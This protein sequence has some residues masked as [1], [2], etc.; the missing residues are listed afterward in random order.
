[1]ALLLA[2]ENYIK[3]W[4]IE[5]ALQAQLMYNI[6]LV[7]CLVK[8]GYISED[9]L[10]R[11]SSEIYKI[12]ILEPD[13]WKNIPFEIIELMPKDFVYEWRV[14]PI[15]KKNNSLVMAISRLPEKS[16]ADEISLLLGLSIEFA[17]C[18]ETVM[19]D[20]A[21]YYYAMVLPVLT[22]S[23][24]N[25]SQFKPPEND[26]EEPELPLEEEEE[27]DELS[28]DMD[29]NDEEELLQVDINN[30]EEPVVMAEEDALVSKTLVPGNGAG[31]NSVPLTGE[32]QNPD[33]T[34]VGMG[35]DELPLA[36]KTVSGVVE[37]TENLSSAPYLAIDELQDELSEAE[38]RDELIGISSNWLLKYYSVACFLTIRKSIATG[39]FVSGAEVEGFKEFEISLN[40]DS[41]AKRAKGNMEV[42]IVEGEDTSIEPLNSFF[43]LENKGDAIVIPAN[44]K[45]RCIG[46]F[47]GLNRIEEIPNKDQWLLFQQSLGSA[48]ETILLSKKIGV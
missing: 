31:F 7:M 36:E 32:E 37:Q 29:D 33:A 43:K 39:F 48:F 3:R 14:F 26:F 46:L 9:Q 41:A 23:E 19:V 34:I 45:G 21:R 22:K 8:L 25:Q 17:L 47:T 11:F 38:D 13:K 24:G 6:P 12:P 10:I 18:P 40:L 15:E 16:L 4:Q 28:L 30:T 20:A 27:S 5:N 2:Q 42:E 44:I 35:E 1:M